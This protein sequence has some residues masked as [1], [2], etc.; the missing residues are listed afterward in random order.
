MGLRC[1]Q[2]FV[3]LRGVREKCSFTVGQICFLLYQLLCFGRQPCAASTVVRSFFRH[4]FMVGNRVFRGFA[5]AKAM[6][7]DVGLQL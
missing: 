4:C 3:V 1:C 5:D 7:W 2:A 6:S